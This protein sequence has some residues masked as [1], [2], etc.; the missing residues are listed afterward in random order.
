MERVIN[1]AKSRNRIKINFYAP[2]LQMLKAIGVTI[3][4]L[5]LVVLFYMLYMLMWAFMG[6]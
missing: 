3:G 5:S 6:C 4:I 1:R 2:F